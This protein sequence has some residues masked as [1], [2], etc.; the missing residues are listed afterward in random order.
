MATMTAVSPARDSETRA[1]ASRIGG[2]AIRPSMKRMMSPSD[3]RT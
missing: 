2:M 3:Q 1:M